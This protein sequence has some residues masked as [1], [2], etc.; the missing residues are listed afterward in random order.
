MK[1]LTASQGVDAPVRVRVTALLSGAIML[2]AGP[3]LAGCGSATPARTGPSAGASSRSAPGGQ[4]ADYRG[5]VLPGL[6]AKPAWSMPY[7]AYPL[8]AVPVGDAVVLAQTVDNYTRSRGGATGS[9]PAVAPG[10]EHALSPAS[11]LEFRDIATGAVRSA[12]RTPVASL[13]ADVWGSTPVAVV[14]FR[15]ETPSDGLSEEKELQHIAGYDQTGTLVKE[16]TAAGEANTLTVA[17]G[18]VLRREG[19]PTGGATATV[20]IQ[21]VGGGPTARLR[22]DLPLCGILLS[23]PTGASVSSQ[24]TQFTALVGPLAFTLTANSTGGREL[25]ALDADTGRQLWTTATVTAPAGAVTAKDLS[26]PRARPL[27][28]VGDRLLVNWVAP[29]FDGAVLALH[30]PRSGRLLATGP[31]LPAPA[32]RV[33]ADPDGAYIIVTSDLSASEFG[34]AAWSLADGTVLWKQVHTGGEK[35]L[36]AASLVN[37]VVYGS[38]AESGVISTNPSAEFIAVDAKTRKILGTDLAIGNAP[39]AGATGHAV[40]LRDGTVFG[41][42]PA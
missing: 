41:F 26:Y 5:P 21:P 8:Q 19:E 14:T 2:A 22:C 35:A 42:A 10:T 6:A 27:A 7:G 23:V 11:V 3:A 1:A 9:P 4:V 37:G 13:R 34:T 38:V 29:G 25:V 24:P 40:L 17:E 39:L 33:F 12:V 30:D 15:T 32:T 16:I 28:M 18:R 20:T 31:T 36:A